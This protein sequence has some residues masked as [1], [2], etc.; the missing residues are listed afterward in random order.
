MAQ[1]CAVVSLSFQSVQSVSQP[2]LSLLLFNTSVSL[3]LINAVRHFRTADLKEEVIRFTFCFMLGRLAS[4]MHEILV[5]N[6]SDNG[7]ESADFG[8]LFSDQVMEQF[9]GRLCPCISSIH[10]LHRKKSGR[11]LAKSSVRPKKCHFG[12]RWKV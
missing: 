8:T 6:F 7:E 11:N 9:V 12:Y 5:R 2:Q 1:L 3:V 10:I 4:E